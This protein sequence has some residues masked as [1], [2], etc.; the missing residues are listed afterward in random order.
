[1]EELAKKM[2]EE[3]LYGMTSHIQPNSADR[4]IAE[5]HLRR[6]RGV[7]AMVYNLDITC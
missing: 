1:M 7:F 4:V 3:V 6:L 2:I 5:I